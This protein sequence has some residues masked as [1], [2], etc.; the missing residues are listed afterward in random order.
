[1][2]LGIIYTKINFVTHCKIS[3]INLKILYLTS[4]SKIAHGDCNVTFNYQTSIPVY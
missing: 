2:F 4:S 3:I 1:M